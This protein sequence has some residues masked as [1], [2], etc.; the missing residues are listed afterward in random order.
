MGKSEIQISESSAFEPKPSTFMLI[1][2]SNPKAS[3]NKN[4]FN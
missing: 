3:I 4:V 2:S 1:L